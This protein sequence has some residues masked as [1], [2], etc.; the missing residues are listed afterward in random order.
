MKRKKQSQNTNNKE[1]K[2]ERIKIDYETYNKIKEIAQ[3]AID[4]ALREMFEVNE[5][6]YSNDMTTKLVNDA[7]E[8]VNL[9]DTDLN[10]YRNANTKK[11]DEHFFKSI[12]LSTDLAYPLVIYTNDRNKTWWLS[13]SDIS[14]KTKVYKEVFINRF[15]NT[16]QSKNLLASKVVN[17]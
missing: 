5:D 16:I 1:F 10:G 13:P 11:G 6:G 12:N 3:E 14:P 4:K 2:M 8:F 17:E 15:G 9:M 7:F